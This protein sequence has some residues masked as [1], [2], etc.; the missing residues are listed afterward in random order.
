MTR[1]LRIPGPGGHTDSTADAA[2]PCR[3]RPSWL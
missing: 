1:L 2:W 3:H